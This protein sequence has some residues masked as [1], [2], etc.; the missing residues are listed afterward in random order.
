[1]TWTF[2]DSSGVVVVRKNSD[3]SQES[4]LASILDAQ[5][6]AAVQPYTPPLV[7]LKSQAQIALAE[8]DIT[9]LRCIES[10]VPVPSAWNTYRKALRAIATGT[11]TTSTALPPKP[12]Y[13]AGT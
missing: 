7:P 6:L 3:G 4:C 1:M 2:A 13:P 9:M 8:S 5:T 11:D 12:P 10:S